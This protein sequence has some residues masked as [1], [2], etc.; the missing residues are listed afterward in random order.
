MRG[1]GERG[2]AKRQAVKSDEICATLVDHVLVHG[3]TMREA[4]RRVQLE[5]L[6]CRLHHQ[7]LQGG[8]QVQ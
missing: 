7:N 8:K 1:G 5:S 6:H 3:M 4:G 2:R